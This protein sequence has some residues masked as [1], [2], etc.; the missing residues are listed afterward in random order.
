LRC[1]ERPGPLNLKG[2]LHGI[3]G[4]RV[5]MESK[6]SVRVLIQELEELEVKNNSRLQSIEGQVRSGILLGQNLGP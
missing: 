4:S 5:K 3:R 6:C 1:E 2:I